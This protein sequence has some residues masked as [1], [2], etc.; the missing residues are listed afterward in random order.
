MA[1][2]E[3]H[4]AQFRRSVGFPR[5][6]TT[7]QPRITVEPGDPRESV[8]LPHWCNRPKSKPTGIFG[9]RLKSTEPARAGSQLG[10]TP[11]DLF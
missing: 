2:P 7:D 4:P 1:G 11:G 3:I 9:G 8:D 10:Q 5:V 6:A